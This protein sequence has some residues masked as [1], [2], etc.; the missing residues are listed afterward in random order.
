M[1]QEKVHKLIVWGNKSK[2]HICSYKAIPI[3][4]RK[5]HLWWSQV[6]NRIVLKEEYEDVPHAMDQAMCPAD[7]SNLILTAAL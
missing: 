7:A 1:L 4:Q 3:S 6:E 5:E 2:I